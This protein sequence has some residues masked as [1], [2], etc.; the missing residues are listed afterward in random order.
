MSFC[1]SLQAGV[2]CSG[3][4]PGITFLPHVSAPTDIWLQIK[5]VNARWDKEGMKSERG[6]GKWKSCQ[7]NGWEA[8]LYGDEVWS[9]DRKID[10]CN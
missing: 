9:E 2:S 8:S 5:N 7:G 6:N 3:H 4:S 1:G 10:F